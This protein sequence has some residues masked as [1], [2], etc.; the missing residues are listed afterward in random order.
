[1]ANFTGSSAEFRRYIGPRLRNLVQTM[2]KKHKAAISSCEKCG[3]QSG[4]ESAHVAGRDRN[5]II[6]LIWKTLAES[7]SDCIDLSVFEEKFKQEHLPLHKSVLILCKRCH[8]EYDA[9]QPNESEIRDRKTPSSGVDLT[10]SKDSET[11]LPIGLFPG[12]PA[13]FKK[14]LLQSKKAEI[15]VI[16]S[17]GS[18]Q[19]KLWVVSRMSKTSNVI[20]NLRSRPEFR[21]GQWQKNGI[22][23]I[24]V[25][26]DS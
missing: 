19:T 18:I 16:F 21:S 1:M 20:G 5:Q 13:I 22:Q 25:H 15:L 6:D 2:T 26:V 12:D 9:H 4:L 3:E 24:E 8:R 14:A 11:I 23:R 17:D 10:S 7:G